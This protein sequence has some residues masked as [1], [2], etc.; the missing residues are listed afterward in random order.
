MLLANERMTSFWQLLKKPANISNERRFSKSWKRLTATKYCISVHIEHP[1][2]HQ[3]LMQLLCWC[4]LRSCYM[5]GS[6]FE[7]PSVTQDYHHNPTRHACR[8]LKISELWTLTS[9]LHELAL[10][11]SI[12]KFSNTCNARNCSEGHH[13]QIVFKIFCCA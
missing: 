1:H 5:P 2:Q 11:T 10:V 7:A 9:S 6:V 8:N 3:Q 13:P 12:I 4:F